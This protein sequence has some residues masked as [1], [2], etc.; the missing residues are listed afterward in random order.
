MTIAPIA[1]WVFKNWG[2]GSNDAV[3]DR[4]T[5][6]VARLVVENSGDIVALVIL[7]LV[8]IEMVMYARILMS[9]QILPLDHFL[10]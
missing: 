8:M 4:V 7:V 5:V 3:V 10:D 2:L 6:I 9:G 1:L